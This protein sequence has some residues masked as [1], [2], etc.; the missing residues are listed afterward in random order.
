MFSS[1]R[2]A[3]TVAAAACLVLLAPFSA[4]VSAEPTSAAQDPAIYT[5][6]NTDSTSRTEI[7]RTGAQVIG[8][9]DG[10]ATVEATP[11]QAQ[12]LRAAGF[13]IGEG[14]GLGEAL[15]R[16]NRGQ[17]APGDFPP[18]YEG[19]HNYDETVAELDR[20]AGAHP[21]IAA[22]SSIGKSVEGRDIPVLKISDNVGQD[23]DE[24]EVLF[25][26]NQHAREHLTTEMCLR[27]AD[28]FTS[29]YA[30]DPAVKEAVDGREIWVIPIVNPD[31]KSYDIESGDFQ[32]WRKNRQDTTGT[33]LNRNWGYKWGCCGGSSDDPNAED[34]RGTAAWSAP[35]T[36]A[37]RDFIDSRVVGGAQQIKAA[38]D[39]HTYSELVL[40]P[41]GHTSDDVTEGMTQEEYDRFARVGGEMAQSN[42][43]TPQQSSDLYVTDGDSLDW[44]WGQHKIL[45]YTFEMYPASGGGLD[46]FYPPADVIEKETTRNDAAV[47]ILLREAG[48]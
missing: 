1:R 25:N 43:Y 36:A 9:R 35:E 39:F 15:Q 48:A 28:R 4:S 10:V 17:A 13:V 30:S 46:G 18:G 19:Y 44:M 5:V 23:E 47:D 14:T 16:I 33:D 6:P 24:P 12:R 11:E 32:G 41:F 34:Y 20:I 37:M 2:K 31:G 40:W 8:V 26:C 7:N 22:K 38:I 27:I 3:V 29:G 21:D 42:G 45:A